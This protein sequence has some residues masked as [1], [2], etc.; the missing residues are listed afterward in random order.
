VNDCLLFGVLTVR[1][2]SDPGA[3]PLFAGEQV[4]VERA[5]VRARPLEIMSATYL[6]P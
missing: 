6:K 4:C 2:S 1:A 3:S 5:D